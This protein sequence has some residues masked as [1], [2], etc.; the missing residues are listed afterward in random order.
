MKA[1]GNGFLIYSPGFE[2]EVGL[3][4]VAVVRGEVEGGEMGRSGID[5]G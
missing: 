1:S 3:Q 2:A 5:S 4:L